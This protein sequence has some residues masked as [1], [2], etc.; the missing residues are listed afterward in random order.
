MKY[1]EKTSGRIRIKEEKVRTEKFRLQFAM[2][3]IPLLRK[4]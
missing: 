3:S 4:K 2:K 1:R